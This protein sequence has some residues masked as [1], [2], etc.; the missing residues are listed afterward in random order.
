MLNTVVTGGTGLVGSHVITRLCAAGYEVRAMVREDSGAALVESLGATAVRGSVEDETCWSTIGAVDAIVHAAALV[1][2]QK[3]WSSFQAVNV[4]G[5]KNAA[6][7]AARCGARL[8]HMSSVSV[9]GRRTPQ[10]PHAVDEAAE[11][12]PLR[13]T[14]YYAR[15]KR[16][17]EEAVQAVAQDA[18][19]SWVTLRPCVIYGE[20]DR[21]F[22]PRIVRALSSGFAPIVGRGDNVLSVVYAGNVAEAVLAALETDRAD[23]PFNV[24]N[25][26]AITQRGFF[27]AVAHAMRRDVRFVRIPKAIASGLAL[28]YHGLRQLLRP[29]GYAGFGIGAARFLA[30]DNPYVSDR[31][32][33]ELSWEPSVSPVSAI[34]RSVKWFTGRS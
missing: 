32:R 19:L 9:Y 3:S 17:A 25:D 16:K 24:A 21:V 15:S 4:Q 12:R 31:A 11:W 33:T 23:G 27:T 20:R 13:D 10:R 18:G 22:L 6:E 1:T 2:Q 7:A 14:D 8:V 5:T 29:K 28:T 26:G 34:E 30:T